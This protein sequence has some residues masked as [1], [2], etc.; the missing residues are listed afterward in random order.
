MYGQ[1]DEISIE[2]SLEDVKKVAL[3]YGFKLEKEKII[4]TTYTTNPRSMM[5]NRYF[6]AFWT[7]R[8]TSAASEKSPKS[9][10]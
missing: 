2:L 5:Q 6:A 3:H 10:C 8:K 9:N 1:D 7:A 4:E